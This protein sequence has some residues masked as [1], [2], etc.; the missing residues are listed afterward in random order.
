VN[1]KIDTIPNE[2][3]LIDNPQWSQ[4]IDGSDNKFKLTIPDLEDV[5][6]G[7]FYKFY[8]SNDIS[9]N[10]ECTKET[11]TLEDDP[12]SF[13]FDQSWN[14]VFLYGKHV[15]DFHILNKNKL[16]TINFSATQEIDRIQQKEKEK[17][18]NI[19]L[20][21]KEHQSIIQ[22]QQIIIETHEEEI[23]TLKMFNTEANNQINQLKQENQELKQQ[24]QYIMQHLGL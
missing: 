23:Q 11:Y 3:R 14:Y 4:I 7:T 17:L 21:V 5:S 12:K 9:G 15:Y 13:I 19:N 22:N 8:M 20:F 6:G 1:L 2:M 24:I 18:N 10:D 16:Y